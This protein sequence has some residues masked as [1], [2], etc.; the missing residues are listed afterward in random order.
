MGR[1]LLLH[2]QSRPGCCPSTQAP[3]QHWPA[4]AGA[5]ILT[6]QFNCSF[7][8]L[9]R[10]SLPTT[11]I[12]CPI[13]GTAFYPFPGKYTSN[14]TSR[15]TNSSKAFRRKLQT[16]RS[17]QQSLVAVMQSQR[18]ISSLSSRCLHQPVLSLKL[19]EQCASPGTAC[20]N[21]LA[22]SIWVADGFCA[23]SR[24]NV[25]TLWLPSAFG[26]KQ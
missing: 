3:L 25:W 5:D 6:S 11:T 18:I 7:A 10:S 23:V 20:V 12:L 14:L 15:L 8:D 1:A 4:A 9:Q 2:S 22:P 24:I 19:P 17:K 16:S 13:F 21:S 26:F